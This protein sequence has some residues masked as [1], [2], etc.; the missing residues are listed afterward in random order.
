MTS[1]FTPEAKWQAKADSLGFTAPNGS[2]VF[3]GAHAYEHTETNWLRWQKEEGLWGPEIHWKR[4]ERVQVTRSSPLKSGLSEQFF[5][6]HVQERCISLLVRDGEPIPSAAL[7][8]DMSKE[9]ESR[10]W[11]V[12]QTE[13]GSELGRVLA[14]GTGMSHNFDGPLR[15][16]KSGSVIIAGSML[17]DE[18]PQKIIVWN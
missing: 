9:A 3:W 6:G 14:R 4:R 11:R 2:M 18:R 12:I 15:L 5:I 10:N 7:L 8:I 13:N 17:Q 1:S 16:T